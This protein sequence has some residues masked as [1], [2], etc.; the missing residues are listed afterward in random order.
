MEKSFKKNEIKE[1]NE[2]LDC[3]KGIRRVKKKVKKLWVVEKSLKNE[4]R[5]VSERH[6]IVGKK[7]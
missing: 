1:V 4:S 5:K 7:S 2:K 3:E 6:G